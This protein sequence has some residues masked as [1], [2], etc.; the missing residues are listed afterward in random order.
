MPSKPKQAESKQPKPN[1][2]VADREQDIVVVS[3]EPIL[4]FAASRVD[5]HRI[6]T[7]DATKLLDFLH[8]GGAINGRDHAILNEGLSGDSGYG[9]SSHGPRNVVTSF[10]D[11][12]ARQ[13]GG[14]DIIGVEH[15]S[16]AL[17]ILVRIDGVRSGVL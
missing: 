13:L 8:A 17:N 5:P 12:L 16:R 1:L 11:S 7:K 9:G 10:Q 14:R 4:W 15:S 6:T 3:D 2:K